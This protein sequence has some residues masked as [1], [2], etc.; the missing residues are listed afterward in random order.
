MTTQ[1][2]VVATASEASVKDAVEVLKAVGIVLPQ[3]TDQ[4]NLVERLIV[5]VQAV[6]A[7][8]EAAKQEEREE[9]EQ[10]MARHAGQLKAWIEHDVPLQYRH[11]SPY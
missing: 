10:A 4:H 9:R 8:R 3:D 6:I 5:A 2:E 1:S 7:A 11:A